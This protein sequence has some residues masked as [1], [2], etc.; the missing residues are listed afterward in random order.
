MIKNVVLDI[1]N[2][3]VTWYPDLHIANFTDRKGEIDFYNRICFQSPQWKAG[4]LGQMTRQES[5]DAICK[6]YPKDE[7]MIRAIMKN[8]DEILR[9]SPEN[10]ALLK[11]LHEAGIGVYYLSNTNPSAFAYMHETHAFFR[12]MDG[13]I[14]SFQEGVLKPGPEIFSR[15]LERYKKAPDE[16]VFVDDTPQNTEAA[17]AAGFATVLLKNIGDLKAELCQF[18]ELADI[19]TKE[20]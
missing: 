17:A 6:K 4:D 1:G 2:V 7:K 8:C 11:T 12:Y 9:A 5:I 10:T 15:F 19:L 3:M 14:A 20:A 13:G 18:P 16:C